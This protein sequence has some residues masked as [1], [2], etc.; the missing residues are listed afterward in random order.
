MKN[1]IE[2]VLTRGISILSKF[3]LLGYLAKILSLEDYGSF[4]LVSYFIFISTMIFGLE[5]Y[6]ISNRELAENPTQNSVFNEH[7]KFFLTLSPIV[8]FIQMAILFTILPSQLLT[9]KNTTF[10]LTISLFDYFSQEVYRYLM[11]SKQYRNGNIQ[12]IYKSVIFLVLIIAYVY[13]FNSLNFNN[14]LLLMVISYSFLLLL[15][16]ISFNNKIYKFRKQNLSLLS[17]SNL[18]KKLQ[19]LWPFIILAL[20]IK[21]IEFSDKFI[22]GKK[23]N[24]EA[25]GIYSFLFSMASIINVFI[26]SGFYI[27]YLP[28]L[29][30]SFRTDQKKF[31]KE[32]IKFGM[33]TIGSSIILGVGVI[34][35]SG[36]VFRIIGKAE[37]LDHLELL[38][39]LVFGFILYNISLIPHL[40]LYVCHAER[41]ITLIMGLAFMLNLVLNFL[42]VKEFNILGSA[43][44]FLITYSVILIFKSIWAYIK[45]QKLIV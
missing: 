39:I 34:L 37:F 33:L 16:T 10:I 9:L 3:L 26:I 2:S 22:I 35:G 15:A 43:Y 40:F 21:G 44:S 42:L 30:N 28:Q 8:L 12:L 20:F 19:I 6:N 17:F 41:A 45:W 14:L 38:N 32:L 13:I 4:Q 24:L 36:Y 25:A 27:I 7:L 1:S 11:I 23:I 29:I 5:Y 18:K 31:K